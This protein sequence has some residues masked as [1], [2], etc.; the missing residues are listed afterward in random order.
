MEKNGMALNRTSSRSGFAPLSLIDCLTERLEQTRLMNRLA[1]LYSDL[2]DSK[3]SSRQAVYYLYAQL[4]LT[5][6]LSP[7]PL[8]LG[9]RACLLILFIGAAKNTR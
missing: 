3:V 8:G 9:W 6:L 5:L 2:L 4:L 1:A 7:L